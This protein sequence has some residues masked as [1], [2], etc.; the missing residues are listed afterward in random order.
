MRVHPPTSPFDLMVWSPK[1]EVPVPST[2]PPKAPGMK[3]CRLE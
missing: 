3:R 1:A 2:M